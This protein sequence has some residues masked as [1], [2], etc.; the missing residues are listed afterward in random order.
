VSGTRVTIRGAGSTTL[1]V[2]LKGDNNHEAVE[3]SKEFVVKKANQGI[4]FVE[5]AEMDFTQSTFQLE[6][7]ASSFL[8]VTFSSDNEAVATIGYRN[9]VTIHSIGTAN[10]TATQQGNN[11]FNAAE[12]VSRQLKV[13]EVVGIEETPNMSMSVYPNP[14]KEEVVIVTRETIQSV[15]LTDILGRSI[16]NY[17]LKENT[18]NI[19]NLSSGLFYVI[20]N[21]SKH[22]KTFKVNKQ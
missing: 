5:L 11:N 13:T 3:V 19:Q 2:T 22:H 9:V 10:I 15:Q 18:I 12:P 4:N 1:K 16:N 6:A 21:T 7:K 20:V 17:T 14:A 8:P